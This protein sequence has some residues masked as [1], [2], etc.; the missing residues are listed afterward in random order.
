M[1]YR[2]IITGGEWFTA[3]PPLLFWDAKDR[4]EN[5]DKCIEWNGI[6]I[7]YLEH[8]LLWIGLSDDKTERFKTLQNFEKESSKLP[9]WEATRYAVI[10]QVCNFDDE[11]DADGDLRILSYA[12]F[13]YDC[14]TGLA[15]VDDNTHKPVP[16]RLRRGVEQL[17]RGEHFSF[18]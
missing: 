8:D 12:L 15:L 13:P 1:P 9:R 6:A 16:A 14:K 11:R 17:M 4:E 3:N 2:Y 7:I 18:M 5:K 10:E